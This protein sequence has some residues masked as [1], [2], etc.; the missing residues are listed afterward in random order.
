MTL[1]FLSASQTNTLY[2]HTHAVARRVRLTIARAPP[3]GAVAWGSLLGSPFGFP[4]ISF[5]TRPDDVA[6]APRGP[7]LDATSSS[8]G[9]VLTIVH[10]VFVDVVLFMACVVFFCLCRCDLT[11]YFVPF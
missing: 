8:P 2:T 5:L 4:R 7:A 3:W 6:C 11:F 1:H 10:A 9:S